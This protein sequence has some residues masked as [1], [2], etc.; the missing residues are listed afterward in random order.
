MLISVKGTS[1]IQ[2]EPDQEIMGDT[3]VL[4]HCS[5]LRNTWPK[6]TGVLEHCSEGETNFCFSIFRGV[7]VTASQ[8]RRRMSTYISLFTVANPLIYTNE[9]RESTEATPY[10]KWLFQRRKFNGCL[11]WFVYWSAGFEYP[12]QTKGHGCSSIVLYLTVVVL[13]RFRSFY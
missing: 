4:S 6:L 13:V 10:F 8:R 12:S 2:L 11:L 9:F 3:P 7:T 5:F 1:R